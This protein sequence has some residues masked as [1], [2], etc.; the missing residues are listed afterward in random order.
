[1]F[2]ANLSEELQKEI[3]GESL[4]EEVLTEATVRFNRKVARYIL[5]VME[6]AKNWSQFETRSNRLMSKLSLKQDDINEVLAALD[7]IA[8]VKDDEGEEGEQE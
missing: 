3:K 7:K 4:K 1:M 8:K 6:L 2:R 5:G